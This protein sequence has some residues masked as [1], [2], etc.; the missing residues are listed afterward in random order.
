[1][2]L[3]IPCDSLCNTAVE[4]IIG[5]ET[6]FF[7]SHRSIAYPITLFHDAI[8][9]LVQRTRFSHYPSH[10]LGDI[11]NGFQYKQRNAYG[12]DEP[13]RQRTSYVTTKLGRSIYFTVGKK[14]SPLFHPF[15]DSQKDGLY[16]ILDIDKC[17]KLT[18]VTYRKNQIPP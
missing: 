2:F 3:F 13:L 4:R 6:E 12:Y 11:R 1:M 15:I 5:N 14:I 9:V 8:L 7:P 18:S 16:Q 10:E 17:Q